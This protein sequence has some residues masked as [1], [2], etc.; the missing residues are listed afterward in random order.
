M[1]ERES[2]DGRLAR[3]LWRG[4]LNR[5]QALAIG[6]A[7][8]TGLPLS[9][10]IRQT[11]SAA[12]QSSASSAIADVDKGLYFAETG[13]N[14]REP[15]LTRWQTA[16]G[17][18]V[19]GLPLSEERFESGVGV[20]QTFEAVSIVYDPSLSAPW[21]LQCQHLP[22]S[23]ANTL[24]PASA[25]A[26]VASCG[27][28]AG[29]CQFYDQ[30]GHTLSGRIGSFWAV[31]GDLAV[32]G[33]PLSEPFVE[34]ASG[35]AIQVFERAVLE[36]HGPN[37]VRVRAVAKQLADQAGLASDPAFVPAPPTNGTSQLVQSPEGLRMRGGASGD[38][39]VIA[40]LPDNA[41]FIAVAGS[42]SAAWVPGYADGYSGWVSS[43]YLKKP[44]PIP[45]L[46]L[47]DWD[48][49]IWQGIV[50]SET[51]VRA[52]PDTSGGIVRV[53]EQGTQIKVP[54][55]VAGEAVFV[56]ASAWAQLEDGNYVFSR[57]VGRNAPIAAPPLPPDAPSS[58]NWI[59]VHL[60]QQLMT[61]YSD[62]TVVRVSVMGSGVPGWDTPTG[63]YQILVR[64]AN[65]TMT[66]GAIGAEYFYRLD[67]VLFT[68]YFTNLGHALH[69]AWWR[70]PE[71]IGR[72][73]SHGCLNLLLDEAR[74]YW[75]WAN[76]GA[77]VFIHY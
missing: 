45:A 9:R 11:S 63:T 64:V 67:D 62:R 42:E 51:N 49:T 26:K 17:Q 5:R 30:T 15:F 12:A 47:K 46:S 32:F 33:M 24:A 28:G 1:T 16:G 2:Q 25:R 4:T 13:H 34:S 75:D 31:N 69:F 37:D 7:S 41:E 73:V 76:I 21:D 19:L 66:S 22:T 77:T 23:F 29:F 18:K 54:K 20:L 74:F 52:K 43:T 68:Q 3:R 40:L 10:G 38:A 55:W 50:L 48:P 44:D 14:L 59:D 39:S 61:A 58:G 65:E 60:T 57:N 27:T 6:A 53:L 56:G 36:D 35:A 8:A 70:T 72:P 71:T